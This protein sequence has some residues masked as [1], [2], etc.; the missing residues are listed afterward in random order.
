MFSSELLTDCTKERSP[1]RSERALDGA[2]RRII[3]SVKSTRPL[4]PAQLGPLFFGQRGAAPSPAPDLLRGEWSYWSPVLDRLVTREHAEMH[5]THREE[6]DVWEIVAEG[7][8]AAEKRARETLW[9]AYLGTAEAFVGKGWTSRGAEVGIEAEDI[10]QIAR[11]TLL[12]CITAFPKRRGSES[13][14]ERELRLR[15]FGAYLLTALQNELGALIVGAPP[16]HKPLPEASTSE[17]EDGTDASS[18]DVDDSGVEH[19]AGVSHPCRVHTGRHCRGGDPDEDPATSGECPSC[20]FAKN[21]NIA[22][23]E[24]SPERVKAAD[25]L[26]AELTHGPKPAREVMR[27]AANAGVGTWALLRARQDLGVRSRRVGGLGAEG[28]W[29][30]EMPQEQPAHSR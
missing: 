5:L 12:D 16:R 13:A 15:G 8:G 23:R 24:A 1:R 18:W 19:G 4:T 9:L 3:S 17:W 22:R 6:R 26:R 7:A 11:M 21:P 30:W 14:L 29:I 27:S 2:Y 10:R 25:L 28:Y 20:H